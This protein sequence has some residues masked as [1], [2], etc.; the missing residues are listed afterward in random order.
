MLPGQ[1]ES[2]Q[3]APPESIAYWNRMKEAVQAKLFQRLGDRPPLFTPQVTILRRESRNGY[4]CEKFQFD[5]GLG[6]LVHGYFA[7]PHGLQGR[8]PAILYHHQHAGEYGIGKEELL[9]TWPTSTPPAVAFTQAGY[10]VMA[11]DA[12][13]FG[14]RQMQGPAGEKEQGRATEESLFKMF[15]WQGKTLWGMMVRDDQL[16]LQYLLSRPE[17]DAGR[18]GATGFSMGSTRTWWLAALDDRIKAAVCVSCLTRYQNLILHGLNNRHGIYYYVPGILRDGIDMEIVVGMIAPRPLLT[19]TGDQDEG[20]PV[21]GVLI[22]NNFVQELY[23][24]HGRPGDFKG[25]VIPGLAH[26]YTPEMWSETLTWFE[27]Y[28]K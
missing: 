20:S 21:D 10:C 6:H 9:N 3:H 26:R 28:L 25:V 13:G 7:I 14:E 23:K 11:I 15:L 4:L 22:I 2:F 24:M 27:K 19:M 5:N 17:V 16:A 12:Y 1:F 8:A 18:V